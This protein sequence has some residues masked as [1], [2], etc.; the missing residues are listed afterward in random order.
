M[1]E[2]KLTGMCEG[3]EYLAMEAIDVESGLRSH[4]IV[5]CT[6]EPI[7]ERAYNKGHEEC[8]LEMIKMG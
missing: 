2:L 5:I 7:C 3:C 6:N 4:K 8:E 1:I